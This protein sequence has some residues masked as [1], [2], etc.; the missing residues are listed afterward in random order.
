MVF[1]ASFN[2]M[3]VISGGQFYWWRK[4]ENWEKTIVY[5]SIPLISFRTVHTN[6]AQATNMTETYSQPGFYKYD[7]RKL[8]LY[9][10]PVS[11]HGHLFYGNKSR[12][13]SIQRLR[14]RRIFVFLNIL[15]LDIYYCDTIKFKEKKYTQIFIMEELSYTI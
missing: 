3:L 7:G 9:D 11:G 15:F 2:N 14:I 5:T 8:R 10:Q 6:K 4:P 1:N 13:A 12:I